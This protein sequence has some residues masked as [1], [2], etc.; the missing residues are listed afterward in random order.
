MTVKKMMEIKFRLIRDGKIAG[1]EKHS[2]WEVTVNMPPMVSEIPFKTMVIDHSVENDGN[3][4]CKWWRVS[5]TLEVKHFI[6][7]DEK[8]QFT[9]C[10]DKKGK[11]IYLGDILWAPKTGIDEGSYKVLFTVVY[12][13]DSAAFIGEGEFDDIDGYSFDEMEVIGNIHENPELVSVST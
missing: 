4:N 3:K 13:D 12:D 1:Y 9:G 8:E 5:S 2:L 7:H 6:F 10:L 11:E